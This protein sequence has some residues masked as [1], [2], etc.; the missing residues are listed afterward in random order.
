MVVFVERVSEQTDWHRETTGFPDNSLPPRR[1]DP[2]QAD[3][4]HA[5]L[6]QADLSRKSVPSIAASPR[7][8][9]RNHRMALLS[10]IVARE[11]LP[12]LAQARRVDPGNGQPV[13]VRQTTTMVDTGELVRLLLADGPSDSSVFVESLLLRGATPE[14]LYMGILSDA[15]RWLGLMWE[16]DRCDFAQVTIGLGRLQQA[17]RLLSPRFQAVSVARGD[18]RCLLLMPAPGDQHTFGLLIL[19]EFFQRAGWRVQGGPK[20]GGPKSGGPNSGGTNAEELVRRTWFDVAG[21]S[22]GSERLL[23]DLA[24]TIR[25][26]RL[27]SCNRGMGVMVGGPLF[28]QRPDLV[29]RA[30]ADAMAADAPEAVR[31]ASEMAA[32]QASRDGQTYGQT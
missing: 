25:R 7:D 5:D 9:A 19:G 16:E 23:D 3:P 26:V 21:F 6:N 8:A 1:S 30:G 18:G 27:A 22:I 4:D 2:R 13:R 28:Q 29:A 24:E 20:S 31:L 32:R 17:A 10:R 12:R 14:A 11:I 15:A